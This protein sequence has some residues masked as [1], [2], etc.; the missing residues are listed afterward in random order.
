MKYRSKILKS[1]TYLIVASYLLHAVILHSSANCPVICKTENTTKIEYKNLNGKCDH[2]NYEE[3]FND[4]I[5]SENCNDISICED[6]HD[7]ISND[8]NEI[9]QLLNID[10]FLSSTHIYKTLIIIK[11][12]SKFDSGLNNLLSQSSDVLII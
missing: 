10:L 8:I 4:G 9:S 11:N 2:K 6:Q 1:F 12:P 7:Y 3:I 5:F